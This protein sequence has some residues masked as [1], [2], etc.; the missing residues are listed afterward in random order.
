MV[1]MLNDI[2]KPIASY[3]DLEVYQET[4]LA[5]IAVNKKILPKLPECEKYD[6]VNQLRRSSKA[7]PR[8]IAEGYAK[9]HQKRG[10]QKYLDDAMAECNE[11]SVGLKQ[12][13]DLYNIGCDDLILLYDKSGRRIYR[14]AEVWTTFK[15]NQIRPPNPLSGFKP[16]S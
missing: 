13:R 12:C 16:A 3:N 8:L 10:F 5:A 14:L 1:E 15:S 6:L 4:Y 9:R 7:V 2:K 11:T